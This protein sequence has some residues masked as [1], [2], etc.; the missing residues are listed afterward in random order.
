MKDSADER[1][2]CAAHFVITTASI[3]LTKFLRSRESGQ[4]YIWFMCN[5]AAYPALNGRVHK[6]NSAPAVRAVWLGLFIAWIAW[7]A[8][9]LSAR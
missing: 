1:A 8:A 3:A 9:L 2:R 4:K 7:R 6:T 5:P